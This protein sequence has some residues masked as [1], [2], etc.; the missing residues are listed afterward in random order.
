MIETAFYKIS[1]EIQDW[2][3]TRR[4]LLTIL[5]KVSASF[6][7]AFLCSFPREFIHIVAA[8]FSWKNCFLFWLSDW[9]FASFVLYPAVMQQYKKD[10]KIESFYGIEIGKLIN[11]IQDNGTFSRDEIMR[12]FWVT[13][14]TYKEIVDILDEKEI[15]LRGDNNK[16]IPN[17]SL[18]ADDIRG[19]LLSP[20]Q[21]VSVENENMQKYEEE[22]EQTGFKV[23]PI[24]RQTESED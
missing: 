4:S 1:D 15:F 9:L 24:E 8:I 3:R 2:I 10:M 6:A 13:R 7:L 5:A 22:A 11:H 21:E 18:T 12:K 14:E 20:T 19:L 23:T 16:R 17:I